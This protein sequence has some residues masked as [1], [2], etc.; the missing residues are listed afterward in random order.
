MARNWKMELDALALAA[1]SPAGEVGG[2]GPSDGGAG[3]VAAL[4]S[5]AETAVEWEEPAA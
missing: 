2:P 1:V 5:S 4:L 3:A